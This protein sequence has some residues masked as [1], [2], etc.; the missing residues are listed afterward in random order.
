[1]YFLIKDSLPLWR[2]GTKY[3]LAYRI[4]TVVTIYYISV[5]LDSSIYE[6]TKT[7]ISALMLSYYSVKVQIDQQKHL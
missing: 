3:I 5:S 4:R 1:M 7:N 6:S 2:I